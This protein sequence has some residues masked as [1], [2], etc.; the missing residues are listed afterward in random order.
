MNTQLKR[1]ILDICVL[2]SLRNFESYG[3]K[4][5]KDVS[6]I[7][8]ITESTLYPILKRLENNNSVLSYSV[9]HNGRLRKYYKITDIGL[10]KIDD[11]LTSWQAIQKAYEFILGEE[12]YEQR[13]F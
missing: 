6:L 13:N 12:S 11:F 7:I 8:P 2:A 5:V 1:G 9:E 4:I 10:K 3:Y